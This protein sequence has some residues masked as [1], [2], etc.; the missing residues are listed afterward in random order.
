LVTIKKIKAHEIT[1]NK[2]SI[3]K[4]TIIISMTKYT[5][6]INVVIITLLSACKK[7]TVSGNAIQGNWIAVEEVNRDG[8]RSSVSSFGA[9]KLSITDSVFT[10]TTYRGWI[11][12][13]KYIIKQVDDVVNSTKVYNQIIF[14]DNMDPNAYGVYYGFS[15][16]KLVL[17][18]KNPGMD[19]SDVYQRY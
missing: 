9:T 11:T 1:G 16:N 10:V 2:K 12:H 19:Y 17:Y 6:I 13:N 8:T 15:A 14:T 18:Y 4:F 5:F 3:N 7:D